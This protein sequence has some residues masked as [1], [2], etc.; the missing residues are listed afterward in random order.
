MVMVM[1]TTM[2]AAM[3]TLTIS[4][5]IM[6]TMIIILTEKWNRQGLQITG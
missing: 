5:M 4:A 6:M 3:V 1:A 2:V